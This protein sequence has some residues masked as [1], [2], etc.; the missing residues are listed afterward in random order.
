M[1]QHRHLVEDYIFALRLRVLL[2][3]IKSSGLKMKY[4]GE[5]VW[6]VRLGDFDSCPSEQEWIDADILL[7]I[8]LIS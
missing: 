7:L 8:L 3:K 6:Q 1:M 5:K 2:M 4:P